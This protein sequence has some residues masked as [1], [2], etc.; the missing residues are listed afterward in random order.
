M[1]L[2]PAIDI[3]GGK[4]VRLRQGDFSREKDYGSD[5]VAQARHF[6]NE[7]AEFIHIVDLDAARTGKPVNRHIIGQICKSVSM[8][9]QAGGGVRQ[10][11]DAEQLKSLGVGRVVVGTA[12]VKNPELLPEMTDCIETA[13][14]LDFRSGS[15]A[16]EGWTQDT[17]QN[18]FQT[19]GKL[20]ESGISAL[21]ST[22]I[23]RDGMLKG[24]NR[25]ALLKLLQLLDEKSSSVELIASGGVSSTEDIKDLYSM[26]TAGGGRKL[27]GLIIGKAIYEGTLTLKKAQ[28]TLESLKS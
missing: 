12:A 1:K 18:L 25:E 13:A 24:P 28:E 27:S 4:C 20:L 10:L 3:R 16:V 6:E 5:P 21:V 19:A 11:K 15:L 2:F 26:Q 14:G 8:F 22:D 7:G 9:V 23:S 17:S